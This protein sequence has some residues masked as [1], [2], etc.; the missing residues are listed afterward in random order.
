V[1]HHETRELPL[2][3]LALARNDGRLGPQIKPSAV[4]CAAMRGARAGGPGPGPEGRGGNTAVGFGPSG[5]GDRPACGTRMMPGNVSAG[6]ITIPTLASI[7]STSTNRTIVD[8]TGL[9]GSYD[10]DLRWTPD[11]MPQ[12]FGGAPPPGAPGLPPIDP[13][14]PSIFTAV[15]EQLGLKLESQKGP[16]DVLVIDKVEPPTPD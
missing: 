7:L 6:S 3:V 9:T 2:Y 4:D 8:K 14:G 1:L 10:L 5:P 16:V 12:G 13:N 15:Q 11:Q